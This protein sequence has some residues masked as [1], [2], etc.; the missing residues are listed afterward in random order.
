MKKL[1]KTRQLHSS[2]FQ[3][4]SWIFLAV[5][6]LWWAPPSFSAP[7]SQ[8]GGVSFETEADGTSASEIQDQT[9]GL[10]EN[11]LKTKPSGS[12]TIPQFNQ[13]QIHYL[14]Y[15]YLYCTINK[16]VCPLP[17]D[18]LLEFDVEL[19]KQTKITACPT[20]TTFWRDWLRNGFEERQ[21]YN[22][23]TSFI[24]ATTQFTNTTRMKYIKCADTV[25]NEL[26]PE[27]AQMKTSPVPDFLQLLK[28]IKESKI[29]VFATGD[30]PEVPKNDKKN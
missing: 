13:N 2:Y 26:S 24:S 6:S 16:G 29:N 22:V 8:V 1:K 5:I 20:L 10:I 14:N 12:P 9:I 28:L 7:N 30:A 18:S 15:V 27:T 23:K 19:T 3:L 17:L 11:Y 4:K 25:K 21:K